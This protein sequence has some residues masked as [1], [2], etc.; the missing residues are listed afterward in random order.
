M[1]IQIYLEILLKCQFWFSRSGAG[2]ENAFVTS[3]QVMP[4]LLVCRL[5]F[6]YKSLSSLF[7]WF[8]YLAIQ[9]PPHF[10]SELSLKR[11]RQ[12]GGIPAGREWANWGIEGPCRVSLSDTYFGS[13]ACALGFDWEPWSHRWHRAPDS[14]CSINRRSSRSGFG[15]LLL[16]A[17]EWGA[18][19]LES[20]FQMPTGNWLW[21]WGVSLGQ[22]LPGY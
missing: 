22:P 8:E 14:P 16:E 18:W 12:F 11:W 4:V 3:P 5:H 6:K 2:S 9:H 17:K 1:Y 19:I 13:M 20:E 10:K 21:W 7:Y 15:G